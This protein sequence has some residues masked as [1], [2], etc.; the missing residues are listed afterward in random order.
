MKLEL[1]KV[2]ITLEKTEETD[3][4]YNLCNIL[5]YYQD[6]C[7]EHPDKIGATQRDKKELAEKLIEVLQNNI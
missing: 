1:N 6:Y 4:I 3:D 7:K 2:T 5:M